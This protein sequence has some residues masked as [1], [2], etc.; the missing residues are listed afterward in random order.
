MEEEN[1]KWQQRAKQ[2]W[3]KDG[4]RN[5]KFFDRC[6]NQR[7]K[8]NEISKLVLDDGRIINDT[9]G[10][11]EAFCQHYMALFTS[12]NPCDLEACLSQI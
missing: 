11:A 1:A 4:D 3:L 8:T 12:L 9:E 7:R 10:I 5:S 2:N 6:A